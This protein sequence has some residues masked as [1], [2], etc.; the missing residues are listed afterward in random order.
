VRC[1]IIKLSAGLFRNNPVAPT[2]ECIRLVRELEEIHGPVR[3][4][5]LSSLALEHKGTGKPTIY[6]IPIYPYTHL[7]I[8]PYIHLTPTYPCIHLTLT[9]PYIHLTPTYLIPNTSSLIPHP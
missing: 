7:P 9:Y 1:T 3:Y 4:I 5:T 8:Y 6:L 2:P